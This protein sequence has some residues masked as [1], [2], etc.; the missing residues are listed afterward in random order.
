MCASPSDTRANR[1]VDRSM[2]M[3]QEVA[4]QLLPVL[5]PAVSAGLQDSMDDVRTPAH[6]T[7]TRRTPPHLH[8][9]CRCAPSRPTHSVRSRTS[10][11]C[12]RER[13]S[14]RWCAGGYRVGWDIVGWRMLRCAAQHSQTNAR[15]S[16]SGVLCCHWLTRAHNETHPRS[17]SRTRAEAGGPIAPMAVQMAALL[18]IL[19]E[20]IRILDDITAS[21]SSIMVLL[22]KLYSHPA[23][24]TPAHGAAL[25]R[26][27]ARSH[28][29]AHI[30]A[31]GCVRVR[32]CVCACACVCVRARVCVCECVG[33]CV[34]AG[35]RSRISR[36]RRTA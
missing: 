30:L 1:S 14:A 18:M 31:A 19:W 27:H 5:L 23:Q 34:R 6:I 35:T 2:A 4:A 24:P 17:H 20:T 33:A 16:R 28:Q 12:S 13:R 7:G 11:C 25:T 8:R 29:R 9:E 36:G 3:R 15:Q 32:A 21:T 22:S 10:A 26:P